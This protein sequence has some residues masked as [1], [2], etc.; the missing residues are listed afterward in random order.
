M[1]LKTIADTNLG[2]VGVSKVNT[3]V[4]FPTISELIVISE[5]AKKIS[6]LSF[7]FN[8][9]VSGN[10]ISRSL[11]L[12]RESGS[13]EYVCPIPMLMPSCGPIAWPGVHSVIPLISSGLGPLSAVLVTR[14]F[15]HISELLAGVLPLFRKTIVASSP[16]FSVKDTS[17]TRAILPKLVGQAHS[18]LSFRDGVL[19][20]HRQCVRN[21]QIPTWQNW[22]EVLSDPLIL[23]LNGQV[24]GVFHVPH[25]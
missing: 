20:L 2:F 24:V 9:L 3:E 15:V 23:S 14:Y 22:P 12:G 5:N 4:G 25:S 21:S 16:S 13:A 6:K 1:L 19:K 17:L 11:N 7:V 8:Q 18:F 10:E